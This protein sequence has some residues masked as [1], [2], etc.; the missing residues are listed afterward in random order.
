MTASTTCVSMQYIRHLTQ[1]FTNTSLLH[2]TNRNN[3]QLNMRPH[4]L[5]AILQIHLHNGMFLYNTESTAVKRLPLLMYM[6]QSILLAIYQDLHNN[7]SNNQS[8]VSVPSRLLFCVR[9]FSHK[10][11][12][13]CTCRSHV[14]TK[15]SDFDENN[16]F[17]YF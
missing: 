5:W 15:W 7:T 16:G 8:T 11:S 10:L 3:I 14:N 2:V 13:Q 1:P 17:I 12:S 4:R 9:A 6:V